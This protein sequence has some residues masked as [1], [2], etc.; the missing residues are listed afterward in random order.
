MTVRLALQA[1]LRQR[2]PGLPDPLSTNAASAGK[3]LDELHR[4]KPE[5]G[6]L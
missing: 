4:L 3:L 1:T 6:G 5:A 2:F